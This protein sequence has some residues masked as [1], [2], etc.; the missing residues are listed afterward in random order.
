MQ[1][2]NTLTCALWGD[3]TDRRLAIKYSLRDIMSVAIG[4]TIDVTI[5]MRE[6]DMF[7]KFM[8]ASSTS[9]I[10]IIAPTDITIYIEFEVVIVGPH[11]GVDGG[12][13]EFEEER[14]T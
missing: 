7:G 8:F 11:D 12:R 4:L 5:C 14:E 2:R 13:K 3:P 9:C 1:W 6:T 10:D